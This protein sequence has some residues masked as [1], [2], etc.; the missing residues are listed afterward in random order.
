MK[1]RLST[2]VSVLLL[3]TGVLPMLIFF[4]QPVKA[5][6]NIEILSYAGYVDSFGNYHVVGEVRNVGD[7][8]AKL[9]TI[10]VV[11]YDSNDAV[12]TG[13]FDLTMLDILLAQRKSPFDIA[14]FDATL[15]AE[16]DHHTLYVNFSTVNSVPASL[17]IL[18]DSSYVDDD[19]SMHISGEVRN[20]GNEKAT[21]VK[22]VATYYNKTGKVVAATS[23]YLDP[24]E[25]D[26]DPG[27][28]RPFEILLSGDRTPYVDSYELV[29]E[30]TEYVIIPEF[31]AWESVLVLF[32]I[33]AIVAIAWARV[34][35]SAPAATIVSLAEQVV[36]RMVEEREIHENNPPI[37]N[38]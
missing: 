3:L 30:S 21:N 27:Q 8:A 32:A 6:A 25:A 37:L 24:T 38:W 11:F 29:A 23:A 15:S 31:S 28:T 5:A 36:E 17:E 20:L 4:V 34:R 35:P 13:R 9:V 19:E 33:L 16:V 18:A 12:I 2:T 14:L 7:Q 10:N 26:L 22:L 1:V